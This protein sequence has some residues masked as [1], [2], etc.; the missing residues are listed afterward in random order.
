MSEGEL[1]IARASTA[2]ARV[3]FVNAKAQNLP[4]DSQS[5][6][7]IFCHMAF[8]L[9]RPLDPVVQEICRVLKP[10][11]IFAAVIGNRGARQDFWTDLIDEVVRC[12]QQFYPQFKPV[13]NGNPRVFSESGLRSL[14]H[15]NDK[16]EIFDFELRIP[17]TPTEIWNQLKD[18]YFIGMLPS[19]KKTQLKTALENF[20]TSHPYPG[21]HN[22]FAFPMRKISWAI[23]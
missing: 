16:L 11:G 7:A 12:I 17:T 21:N 23:G 19:E 5:V 15:E 10:R 2:D 13:R 8:M 9:M 6:D 22:D 1:A 4:L 3:R 20:V 18:M 14:F